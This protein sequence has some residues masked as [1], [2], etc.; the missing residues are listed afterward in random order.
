MDQTWS[1]DSTIIGVH[2]NNIKTDKI[3][4]RV[5][6]PGAPESPETPLPHGFNLPHGTHG[7]NLGRR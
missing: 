1:E 4:G 5:W 6:P 2:N 3:S 7:P